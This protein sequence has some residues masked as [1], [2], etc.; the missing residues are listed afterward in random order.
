M[1]KDYRSGF[2]YGMTQ[3]EAE[4]SFVKMLNDAYGEDPYEGGGNDITEWESTECIEKPVL[5]A[6]ANKTKAIKHSAQRS[7]KL[8]NGF[9]ITN[10][11]P[12]LLRMQISAQYNSNIVVPDIEEDY[13]LKLTDARKI[14]DRI[15]MKHNSNVHVLPCRLWQDEKT[16]RLS[17][18]SRSIEV[19]PIGGKEAKPGKWHFKVEVRI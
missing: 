12:E 3:Y 9:R 6:A 18:P 1:G 2:A 13:A 19:S 17:L 16:E 5:A 8:V 14:A 7:G 4:R 11:T 10:E 15:A